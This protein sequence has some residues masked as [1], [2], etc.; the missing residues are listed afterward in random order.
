MERGQVMKADSRPPTEHRPR[1][2]I[3][4]V[5]DDRDTV[6]TFGMLLAAEG[7]EI[8]S[9]LDGP[10]GLAAAEAFAPDVVLLD[11]GLPGM[12]GYE[13]ARQ[14]RARSGK[15]RPFLIAIT[16]YGDDRSRLWSEE[17]GIDLHL[18]KPVEIEDLQ[19]VLEKFQ[20]ILLPEAG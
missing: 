17:S 18:V 16:A 9:A 5:E 10:S 2:R 8:R 12:D 3:L 4:M 15:R 20:T 1:L 7:H 11:I 6:D 13:L 14:L 19:M